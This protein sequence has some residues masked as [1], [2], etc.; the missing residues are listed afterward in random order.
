MARIVAALM[1]APRRRELLLSLK[2]CTIEACFSVPMLN[3]T[4]GNMPFAI[5][6]AVM[7]LGW[8]DVGIGWLAA[9]PFL[10]LFIQPP[11]TYLLQRH[12]SLYQIMVGGFVLNA[13]PWTLIAFLPWWPVSRTALFAAIMFVSTLANAVCG[14][15]WWASV[16]EL[17]P[18]GIRGK[19]FGTRTMI[20]SFWTLVV[21]VAAGYFAGRAEDPVWAFGLVFS[22]AAA[23]R[24][25]GLYFLA[26]M[27]F[28]ASVM[29][30]QPQLSPWKTWATVLR[31]GGFMRLVL[32][33]GLF[34]LCLNLGMPF[35]S[36]YV[37]TALPLT[38]GDLTVLTTLATVGSLLSLKTW[39]RLSDRFGNKPVMLTSAL[40]WL[41][42]AA[43]AWLF[44]GPSRY[45]HL[46]ASY[47]FTGFMMAGFQQVGQFNL[48]IK[49][50]PATHRAH[51][52]SV[53]F[54]IS[55]LLITLGPILGGLALRV[56]PEN[57]GTWLGEPLRNYHVVI[58]GS[59]GMCVLC[60]HLLQAIAEPAVRP[61]R[62][63]VQVMRGMREFNPMLGLTT[64]AEYVFTPR[65]LSRLAHFSVR[66]LRRQTSAV[67]EVG[68]ELIEEGWRALKRPLRGQ[69]AEEPRPRR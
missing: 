40:A 45:A 5:G 46:Y 14:V 4:Q 2:Y 49:M 1:S 17:V 47:F 12:F 9:M 20:F 61:V 19:F 55:N 18:L 59:L 13:L 7:V 65:G 62:E 28:P 31:N 10:C 39:G 27:K 26:R 57:V 43:A 60:L 66:T 41:V 67:S 56:V 25:I 11:L 48:M 33:T 8:G 54:S 52:I 30:R 68:E 29:E 6:F 15:A 3:L 51:Y 24:L 37:L 42:A 23:S 69:D 38:L 32:F 16:S 58:V 44:A 50:V 22:L 21:T 35:Y 63:L 64:L 36:V 53:Y 34:G